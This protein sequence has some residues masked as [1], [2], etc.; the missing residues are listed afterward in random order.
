MQKNYTEKIFIALNE[1]EIIEIINSRIWGTME[2]VKIFIELAEEGNPIGGKKFLSVRM[3][4]NGQDQF[5]GKIALI[6][7]IWHG[8]VKLLN[9]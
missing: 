1:D 7:A 8:Q 6:S 3:P 9:Y 5:G 2:A 4:P